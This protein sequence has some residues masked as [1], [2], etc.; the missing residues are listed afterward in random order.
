MKYAHL[1]D[2]HLGSWRDLKMRDLSTKAFLTAMDNCIER[3]VD[4]IL[5]TGD[6]FNTSLPSLDILKI[7]TKKLKELQEKNIPFYAIPGSHDFSPSG[8]TMLDVYTGAVAIIANSSFTRNE[9]VRIGVEEEKITKIAHQGYP[10]RW[11]G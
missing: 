2:S 11:G 8:K 7:A 6:L 4:F 1:A 5:F 9:L 3:K 10:R